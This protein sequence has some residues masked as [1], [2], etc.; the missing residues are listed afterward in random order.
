M[1]KQKKLDVKYMAEL[2]MMI[3][4][5]LVMNFTPLGY[6]KTPG[7]SI[8]LMTVPVA[9]G[10]ILLGPKGGFACGLAFGLTSFYQALTGS[11]FGAMLL[12]INP[13][14]C[15][16]TCIVTRALEGWLCGLIF[17][18][19]HDAGKTKKISYYVA[20]LSCPL[21]NTV[22]FMSSLVIFFYNTD[23][24]QGFVESLGVSNPLT[25][26]LAFVGLQGLIEAVICFIIASIVSRSLAAAL[27]RA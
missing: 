1:E 25:F 27:K 15:A 3:A 22:L 11:P 23:Y 18:A 20:S 24:I 26:V 9:I 19:L 8:T 17:K 13:F 2:A 14:G 21:L 10:A 5:I 4:I 16:V 7:L 6:I 12:S